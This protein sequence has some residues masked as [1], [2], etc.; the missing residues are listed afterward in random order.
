MYCEKCGNELKDN[1]S[2][3]SKC[4]YKI[5]YNN[6]IQNKKSKIKFKYVFTI[7]LFIIFGICFCIGADSGKF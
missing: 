1:E 2:I 6:A 5:S 7:M 3:C 4:G